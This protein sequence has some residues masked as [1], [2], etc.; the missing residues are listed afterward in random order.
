MAKI[1]G[2]H[3]IASGLRL[4]IRRYLPPTQVNRASQQYRHFRRQ[5]PE[6]VLLPQMG[7]FFEFYELGD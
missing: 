3:F 1:P 4:L 6:A 7:K 5:F 2:L